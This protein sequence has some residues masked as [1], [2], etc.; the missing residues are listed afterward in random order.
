MCDSR[1]VGLEE[2]VQT[3]SASRSDREQ[4]SIVNR[5]LRLDSRIAPTQI[6]GPMI[7][8][9]V[10]GP[11]GGFA[12]CSLRPGSSVSFIPHTPV[13]M[14]VGVLAP[15][16]IVA[17]AY[18]LL[19]GLMVIADKRVYWFGRSR[20]TRMSAEVMASKRTE[21]IRLGSFDI[22]RW[23]GVSSSEGTVSIRDNLVRCI[24]GT[25][26][27]LGSV[28][29]RERDKGECKGECLFDQIDSS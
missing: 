18:C 9:Q 16:T 20:D 1:T 22:G 27:N 8:N 14:G 4:I 12:S 23:S 3:T 25:V 5:A 10:T 19:T 26:G 7:P 15:W 11:T 21:A 29:N 28:K 2:A 24:L 17:G 13:G 6:S